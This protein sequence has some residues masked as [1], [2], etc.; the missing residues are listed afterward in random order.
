MTALNRQ[1]T[2]SA[3]SAVTVATPPVPARPAATNGAAPPPARSGAPPAPAPIPV[4]T[5]L[6]DV[7]DPYGQL[8]DLELMSGGGGAYQTDVP[9][10]RRGG[11]EDDLLF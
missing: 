4:P 6:A 1:R 11:Q 5:P 2:V 8:G 7:D 10:P 9:R 3:A